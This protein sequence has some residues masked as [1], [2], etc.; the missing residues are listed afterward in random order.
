MWPLRPSTHA[1]LMAY[2]YPHVIR[3]SPQAPVYKKGSPHRAAALDRI[4]SDA[5]CYHTDF[6][7]LSHSLFSAFLHHSGPAQL[8]QGAVQEPDDSAHH[9]KTEK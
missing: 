5:I 3:R 9:E 2:I 6:Y 4:T 7:L 1:H 8:C